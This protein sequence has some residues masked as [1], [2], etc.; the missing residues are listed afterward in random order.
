MAKVSDFIVGTVLAHSTS[1]PVFLKAG[2]EVPEG[3]A[4]DQSL[5]EE[6]PSGSRGAKRRT[7]ADS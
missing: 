1:G 2:D 6:V 4:I 3:A 5:I 7:K